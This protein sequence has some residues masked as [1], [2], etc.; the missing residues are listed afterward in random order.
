MPFRPK[1]SIRWKVVPVKMRNRRDVLFSFS[2]FI[3]AFGDATSLLM[4]GVL[5]KWAKP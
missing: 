2:D 5:D 4:F 3:G 1:S